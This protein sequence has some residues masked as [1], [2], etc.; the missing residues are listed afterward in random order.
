MYKEVELEPAT[1]TTAGIVCQ[2]CTLCGHQ[3]GLK[4]T[5][6]LGHSYDSWVVTIEPSCG[7]K[8]EQ[9]R[10]CIRCGDV[11]TRETPALEHNNTTKTVPPTC[12]EDG[13]DLTKCMNCGE[14]TKSNFV[15]ATGHNYVFTETVAPAPTRAMISIPAPSAKIPASS[16]PPMRWVTTLKAKWLLPPVIRRVTP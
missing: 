14:E 2:E 15:P 11:E 1:C 6:V 13:Y 4:N 7:V 10:T 3:T 16:I 5:P 9:A 8:G 12:T